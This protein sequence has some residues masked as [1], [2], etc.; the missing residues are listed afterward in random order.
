MTT[1]EVLA[2][3]GTSQC[4]EYRRAWRREYRQRQ[5]R[6]DFLPTPQAYNIID[7]A[8]ASGLA[9]SMSDAID[10]ALRE[11]QI[12]YRIRLGRAR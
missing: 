1:A 9:L 2:T 7:G 6:I 11:L 4:I 10:L 12:R 5:P 3:F 8:I